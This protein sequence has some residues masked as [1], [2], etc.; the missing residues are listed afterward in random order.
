[1]AKLTKEPKTGYDLP[2]LQL[3][4]FLAQ[5]ASLPPSDDVIQG[6]LPRHQVMLLAGD[7]WQG[8]SLEIQRLALAFGAGTDYHGLKLEKC[9]AL[10]IT[11]EG[12]TEGIEERFTK[13]SEVL[14]SDLWPIIKMASHPMQINLAKGEGKDEFYQMLKEQKEKHQVSVVL[15]DSFPYIFKGNPRRD[16][17]IQSWW[18]VLQSIALDLELTFIIVWEL[19]KLIFQGET[20]PEM[21]NLERLK[22]AH[23]TAY[24]VN[25]VVAIGELKKVV[26]DKDQGKSVRASLGHRIVILKAKDAKGAFEP[27]KVTLDRDTLCWNGEHWRWDDADKSYRAIADGS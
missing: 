10:Y 4:Q 25:T 24:K 14:P 20:E 19:T 23:T 18:E 5:V 17:D 7:P 2:P 3:D 11:W 8:K 13:L 15:V 6:I 21:F 9:R 12:A 16:E 26:K 22:T 27:L 1:M